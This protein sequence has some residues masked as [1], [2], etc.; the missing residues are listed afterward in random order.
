MV[1]PRPQQL[2]KSGQDPSSAFA[3]RS[4]SRLAD[5]LSSVATSS[6][7][8]SSKMLILMIPMIAYSSFVLTVETNGPATTC[9]IMQWSI[10]LKKIIQATTHTT[11]SASRWWLHARS[12]NLRSNTRPVAT[13]SQHFAPTKKCT[14]PQQRHWQYCLHQCR[15]FLRLRECWWWRSTTNATIYRWTNEE[16]WER[17][18]FKTVACRIDPVPFTGTHQQFTPKITP[19]ELESMKDSSGYI[20]Y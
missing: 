20:R 15:W 8:A 7:P 17:V 12:N 16:D 14:P 10:M 4:R 3:W 13:T 2:T 9:N 11:H 5:G 19:E 1:S 6:I 18:T